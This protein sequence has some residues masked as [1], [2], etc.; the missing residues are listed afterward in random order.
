MNC[1][2]DLIDDSLW[3]FGT[4][5]IGYF[6]KVIK[7]LLVFC[8]I[9]NTLLASF[10]KLSHVIL[11]YKNLSSHFRKITLLLHNIFLVFIKENRRGPFKYV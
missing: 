6:S 4:S 5:I 11:W 7:R 8:V 9:N 10:F 3:L 2:I 1:L